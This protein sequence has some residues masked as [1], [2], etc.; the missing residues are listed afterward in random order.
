MQCDSTT[1]MYGFMYFNGFRHDINI[2]TVS[3]AQVTMNIRQPNL[4]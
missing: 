3:K 4:H 2:F 1:N